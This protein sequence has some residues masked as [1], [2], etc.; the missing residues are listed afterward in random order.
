LY[1][2]GN[3]APMVARTFAGCTAAITTP[4]LTQSTA[5]CVFS[6]A[7]VGMR[8]ST[9]APSSGTNPLPAASN[10]TITAV[11][12][13][14]KSATLSANVAAAVA[15]TVNITLTPSRDLNTLTFSAGGTKMTSSAT[16]LTAADVGRVI[17]IGATAGGA[18]VPARTIITS[19]DAGLATLSNALGGTP[20]GTTTLI[21]TLA[22]PVPVGTYTMTVV[23]TGAIGTPPATGYTQSIISSGSTFTVSDF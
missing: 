16:P 22:S 7:D 12:A 2:A 15:A 8:V 11:A 19:V 4:T 21:A 13:D 23:S 14:G 3:M 1:L 20:S 5:A 18:T 6:Q 10:V 17:T 9:P